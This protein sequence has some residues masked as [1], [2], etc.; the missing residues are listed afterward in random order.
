MY[1]T[2]ALAETFRKGGAHG[3]NSGRTSGSPKLDLPTLN[4]L[5]LR[6]LVHLF[7]D[8]E[9]LFCERATV[10]EQGYSRNG[11]SHRQTIIALLGLG[12]LAACEQ[13]DHLDVALIRDAVLRDRNWVASA[14]DLG[15]L[16]WL[17]AAYSP[18]E[19][20]AI[21]TEFDFDRILETYADGREARTAGLAWFLAGVAQAALA[22][23]E[24]I[25]S[26]T[27]VAVDAYRRLQDNQGSS[28]IFGNAGSARFARKAICKRFGTFR[29]Q[30]SAIYALSTFARAFQ[31]E[32]PLES[33]LSCAN[34]ICA[35]Q[36]ELGEWW[37][38]YDKRTG[39]V[40]NHYPVVSSHQDGLAPCA[41]MALEEATGRSFEAAILKGLSWISG[42]NEIGVDLRNTNQPLIW[43]S[44]DFEKR[45]T[46]YWDA[47]QG[48]MNFSKPRQM[49]SLRIRYEV[50]PDHLGWLLCAFG[51]VGLPNERSLAARA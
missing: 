3:I 9:R 1:K 30:I 46:R 39:R 26:L 10:G 25:S 21:L 37:S 22:R 29:D 12:R 45:I 14:E 28:G 4:L 51:G 41:L 36:G 24:L 44:I 48:F 15:L 20:T 18:C 5:A 16:T 40:V 47:A 31:I 34:S 50:R 27:D 35:L 17:S 19:L 2:E 23:P 33:A 11:I 32:E 7:D 49:Q 6:S 8:K 13:I 38:L 42:A 43:D